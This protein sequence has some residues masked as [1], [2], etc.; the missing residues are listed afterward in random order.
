ML[1][2]SASEPTVPA[3]PAARAV[4][5]SKIYGR[6]ET[7][8]AALDRIDDAFV[9]PLARL[10]AQGARVYLGAIHNM[11]R[12]EER[13]ALARKYLPDF[14][15]GAYCGLGR[16]PA[17]ELPQVLEQHIRASKLIA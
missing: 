5:A 4:A 10:D 9:A 1:F 14:G 13:I 7:E 16:T 15:V 3:G 8:V 17:A 12:F 6:G 2:R 11:E